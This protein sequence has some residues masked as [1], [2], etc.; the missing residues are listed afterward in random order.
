MNLKYDEK[1]TSVPF[2]RD[3]RNLPAT[4]HIRIYTLLV[5]SCRRVSDGG[6]GF[7]VGKRRKGVSQEV[8][9]DEE[10]FYAR[11]RVLG[12]GEELGRMGNGIWIEV[13][14]SMLQLKKDE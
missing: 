8:K 13:E 9:R 2:R 7:K 11:F 12:A 1:I 4:P 14:L 5:D 10:I 3:K 6:G